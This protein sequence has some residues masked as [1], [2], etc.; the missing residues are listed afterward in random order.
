MGLFDTIKKSL[1]MATGEFEL[2]V[3]PETLHVDGELQ[4]ELVLRAHRDLNIL[5]V[6][7]EL[8]HTFPDEWGGTQQEVFEGVILA[9]R[10]SLRE[11]EQTSWPF[12]IR[13]PPQIAPTMDRFGW[14]VRA[15]AR[16]QG[17]SPVTHEQVV[18]VRLSPIMQAVVDIVQG[19]F[20]FVFDDAGA[21]E[22][23]VWIDFDPKGAVKKMY[24][25]LEIAF[26]EGEDE[27]TLWV[28]LEPFSS[29]VIRRYAEHFDEREG[30]IE[31]ELDK[32]RYANGTQV[33]REGIFHL[34]QP[35]FS[36][37]A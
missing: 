4:G 18:Q 36:P 34:L 37:G 28:I 21:D 5:E 24:R 19:Q 25:D 9:E 32:R 31:L 13:L 10:I 29:A 30:S 33:D 14:K 1:G 3:Q 6:D 7:L 16:L 12:F 17:K 8:L 11:G 27:L 35:L 23:C 20:G 15:T 2:R 22:E 26:D